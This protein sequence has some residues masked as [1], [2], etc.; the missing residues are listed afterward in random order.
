[1]FGLTIVLSG[2]QTKQIAIQSSSFKMSALSWFL[3]DAFIN[4]STV[5][6]QSMLGEVYHPAGACT[7]T[8]LI[9]CFRLRNLY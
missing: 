1:M 2:L 5:N 8:G 3:G 6:C 4:T 7:R 9:P